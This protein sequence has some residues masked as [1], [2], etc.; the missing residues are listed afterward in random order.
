MEHQ[1]TYS[2]ILRT[3]A[4]VMEAA[5]VF[6]MVLGLLFALGLAMRTWRRSGDGTL[7]YTVLRRTIGGAIL[8]GLEILVAGDLIRTVTIDPDL[9]NV[10]VLGVIVMI[11]T[12]L[13]FSLE[14]EIE[15]SLPWRRALTRSG[16]SVIGEAVKFSSVP[17][18]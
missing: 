1:D 17:H 14:I 10:I 12:F 15:G 7:A 11:R 5:G 13:S 18:P 8:V 3:V 2:V 9:R 4:R 16:A 6:V